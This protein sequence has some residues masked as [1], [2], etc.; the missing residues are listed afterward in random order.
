[1]TAE[2]HLRGEEWRDVVGVPGYR[3]S[4]FGRVVSFRRYPAGKFLKPSARRNYLGKITYYA[5]NLGHA[6]LR[7]V[8]HLVLEAF[9]GHRPHGLEGCH[10]NGDPAD[11]S[12]LN[13]RWDTHASNMEDSVKHG[14][15]IA[16][17]IGWRGSN[18]R[19]WLSEDDVRCIWAEPY[20]RGVCR[21]CYTC[22]T[23]DKVW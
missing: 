11:N 5:V 7:R 6:D 14:T 10:N 20:F 15:K 1:M 9:V 18:R 19:T 16:P 4:S 13:L 22:H 2:H 3:V 21:R 8:H 17:P 23:R 12:A